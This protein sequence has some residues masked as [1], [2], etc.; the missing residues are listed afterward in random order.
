MKSLFLTVDVMMTG[1]DA[2]ICQAHL[3]QL[4][5]VL[6][7]TTQAHWLTQE[8][9]DQIRA[10]LEE[11]SD[12]DEDEDSDEEEEGEKGMHLD[13]CVASVSVC[14]VCASPVNRSLHLSTSSASPEGHLRLP[15][16][17]RPRNQRLEPAA[18]ASPRR[19]LRAGYRAALDAHYG[20]VRGWWLCLL[21][22]ALP[23]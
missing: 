7:R 23:W 14:D 8:D 9:V 4:T 3:Q 6:G 17:R 16:P 10:D 20:A 22:C 15:A 1:D 12:E 19:R 18:A 5:R 13:A 11:D 2:A 21:L